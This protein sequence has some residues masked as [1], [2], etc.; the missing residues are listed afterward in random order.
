MPKKGKVKGIGSP[1]EICFSSCSNNKPTLFDWSN[2]DSDFYILIDY[3]ILDCHKYPKVK[4]IPKIGWLCE[5]TTIFNNLYN[6]LK[7]DYKKIFNNIDYIFTS[8]EYLLSLD[9]RFKF[10]YS[11]SNIPWLKKENW[12]IYKKT[13]KCSM[14]C[15]EKSMCKLH[16]IRKNIAKNNIDKFDLFG[17]FLNSPY[18]GEKYDGFYKKENALKDYMFTVVVQNN[19]Q[20]YFFAEMLTDCFAFGTI[21]IYL[22]NPKIDLFFDANGIISINSEEDMNKIVVDEDLYYSKM[23]SIKNNLEKLN[24]MKMSDDYLYEQ[25]LKLMEI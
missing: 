24:C 18:T 19:N 16:N 11:C 23:E 4:N 22:G 12:S 10:C 21:P 6:I 2:E 15:S 9:P 1:F 7:Y 5:S 17:G 8:D 14:I 3:S 13:K 25:C 20:P